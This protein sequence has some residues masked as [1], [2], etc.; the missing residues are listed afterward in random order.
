MTDIFFLM[1]AAI[2][3]VTAVGFCLFAWWWW[4]NRKATPVYAYITFLFLT[5]VL[6]HINLLPGDKPLLH[7]YEAWVLFFHGAVLT[8]IVF[9]VV[10]K[11]IGDHKRRKKFMV[12]KR[13]PLD[14]DFKEEVLIIDDSEE[15]IDIL[16]RGMAMVFPNLKIHTAYNANDA[17]DIFYENTDINLIITDINLPRMNGFELCEVVKKQ[18][19]WTV[20]VAMTGYSDD[21]EFWNAREIGFDD[22]IAKPFGLK[23]IAAIL[24]RE[25]AKISRW[26]SS[27]LQNRDRKEAL[28]DESGINQNA[29][30]GTV[31]GIDPGES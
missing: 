21:Y 12:R 22:Y 19:P 9:H 4:K 25:L 30:D 29:D 3:V 26:K 27:R 10:K 13:T 15:V 23:D 18:C 8:G 2:S 24:R 17:L 31:C 1:H 28:K 14:K 11:I 16:R 6:M 20:M 5:E 7:N